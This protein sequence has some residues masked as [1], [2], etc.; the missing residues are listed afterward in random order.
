MNIYIDESGSFVSAPEIGSWNAV[1]ALAVPEAS[2]RGLEGAITKLKKASNSLNNQE[3]KL[4][5]IAETQYADFLGELGNLNCVLFCTAT[6]AGLNT[7]SNVQEHQRA[8]AA[9]VL[10]HI[11]KM[12]HEGG[13]KG[14]EIIAEQITRLPPQLYVQLLCQIELMYEVVSRVITYYAQ[15]FPGTLRE[16]RWR[17]DQKNKLITN[18][19]DSF[20]KLSP[21]ILQTMSITQP[22]LMVEGLDYSHMSQYEFNAGEAPTYLKDAYGIDVGNDV[23]NIKKLILGNM[24]FV[25]S[26]HCA[27]IQA[28]DLIVSGIRKCLRQGFRN[29]DGMATL[30]G[31][32]MLQAIHNQP[33]LRL[34]SFGVDT[35]MPK[36]TSRLVDLMR[37]HVKPMLRG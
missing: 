3:I 1:A 12:Q 18:F 2:R 23:L 8:Q 9:K 25:D 19:E 32:L 20:Q 31:K 29:N 28:I 26:K 24:K 27:G 14:L 36:E 11:D 6:D 17:I 33:P 7:L 5:E 30:L 37:A 35:T 21:A 4:N 34:I 10:E 22:L 16:I 15:Y 13:R